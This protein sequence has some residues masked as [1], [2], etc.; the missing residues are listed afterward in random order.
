VVPDPGGRVDQ[1]K[2]SAFNP[3]DRSPLT[4]ALSPDFGEL[5]GEGEPVLTIRPGF[6]FA[7]LWAF[8]FSPD[9]AGASQVQETNSGNALG[10][11]K[12][13]NFRSPP[14]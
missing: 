2:S 8:I 7:P 11:V 5:R 9:R 6:R 3:S 14:W 10:A 1:N 13:F 12:E 4:P